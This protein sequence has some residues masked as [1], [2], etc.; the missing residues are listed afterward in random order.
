MKHLIL[1][2]LLGLFCLACEK[3]ITLDLEQAEDAVVIEAQ[4]TDQPGFNFVKLSRVMAFNGMGAPPALSG[5][6]VSIS[7]EDGIPH[8]FEET[9]SGYYV[10]TEADYKGT[11]GQ[12]YQLTVETDGDIYTASER[13]YYMPPFDSL[14]IAV[15]EEELED[16]D[17]EGYFYDVL[18]YIKEPQETEDYYL[19]KF[20]RNDT[21][22]NYNGEDVYVTDDQF[23]SGDI[24]AFPGPIYFK[25]NDEARVE[26]YSLPRDGYI[27]FLDI[28]SNVNSDGGMFSGQPANVR[29]NV[30]G[31]AV[32]Y[33][34]VSSL[35]I[36]EI[37]V[38]E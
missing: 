38:R 24:E 6:T 28:A 20:Y 18:F 21:L 31:G 27:Y 37:V 33:F 8:A 17:E 10:P 13:M 12:T 7:G 26:M 19:V 22:Q 29:G 32:G 9:T 14:T 15:D 25:E 1:F 3:T 4:L 23:L 11:V 16:P 2:T 34:Q 35:S 30:Q 5:A 36:A